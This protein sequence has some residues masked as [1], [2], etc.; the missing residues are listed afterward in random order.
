[1][2]NFH[3]LV[4][5]WFAVKKQFKKRDRLRSYHP[6]KI[7]KFSKFLPDDKNATYLILNCFY[8]TANQPKTSP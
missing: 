4:F 2:S 8:F 1:M 3:G 6:A 7:P 5:G